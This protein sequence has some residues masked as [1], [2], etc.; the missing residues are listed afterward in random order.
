LLRLYLAPLVKPILRL[1]RRIDYRE[2]GGAP[3]LGIDG[4]VIVAHGS[5]NARALRNAVRVAA[6]TVTHGFVEELRTRMPHQ[7]SVTLERTP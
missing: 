4:V 7:P 1:Y 3:L 5:S 6:E 2:Y